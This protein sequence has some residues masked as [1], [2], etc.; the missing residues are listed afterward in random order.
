MTEIEDGNLLSYLLSKGITHVKYKNHQLRIFKDR[1]GL[2]LVQPMMFVLD[3]KNKAAALFVPLKNIA[4]EIKYS[5]CKNFS[6]DGNCITILH[7]M[8]FYRLDNK[9]VIIS[10]RSLVTVT[11]VDIVLVDKS[12]SIEIVP[13]NNDVGNDS[14]RNWLSGNTPIIFE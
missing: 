5:D 6:L 1:I 4:M 14:L 9:L 13:R 11:P 8:L 10:H 12:L 2:M 7:N 3:V